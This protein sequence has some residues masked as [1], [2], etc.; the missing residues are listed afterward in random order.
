MKSSCYFLFSFLFSSPDDIAASLNLSERL[1][2]L[3]LWNESITQFIIVFS[4]VRSYSLSE[5]PS[6]FFRFISLGSYRIIDLIMQQNK[7]Y[8]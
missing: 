5:W 8:F 4:T 1:I 7:Q 3:F 2:T 6:K